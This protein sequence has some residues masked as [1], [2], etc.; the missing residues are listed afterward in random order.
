MLYPA[1]KDHLS[2]LSFDYLCL[3]HEHLSLWA[4]SFKNN[5][6]FEWERLAQAKIQF[7]SWVKAKVEVDNVPKFLLNIDAN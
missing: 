5:P 6:W 1:G 2:Q 7:T 4:H 3:F